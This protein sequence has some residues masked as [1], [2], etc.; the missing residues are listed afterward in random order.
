MRGSKPQ[1]P[2]AASARHQVGIRELYRR[3]R[4]DAQ[5]RAK[6][7]LDKLKLIFA[8][9]FFFGR[10]L[11]ELPPVVDEF[12]AIDKEID[13][14]IRRQLW[15]AGKYRDVL[16]LLRKA[17]TRDDRLFFLAWWLTQEKVCEPEDIVGIEVLRGL[18]K[19][20][21]P[22]SRSD[23]HHAD[24]VRAWLPYFER[25]LKDFASRKGVVSDLARLGYDEAAVEAAQLKR[26]PILAVCDWLANG[27]ASSWNVDARTLQNA[28]SRIY[29]PSRYP[30]SPCSFRRDVRNHWLQP[31]NHKFRFSKLRCSGPNLAL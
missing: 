11:F 21:F 3:C 4:A 13:L 22:I 23:F 19:K 17:S 2:R 29:G 27:R 10:P 25:L 26:S 6:L 1:A 9:E 15:E 8:R 7:D 30:R 14:K 31:I 5:N 12:S 28:Y 16:K 24:T 20:T 18:A